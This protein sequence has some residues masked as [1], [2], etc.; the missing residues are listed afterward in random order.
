MTFAR[1]QHLA[2][3]VLLLAVSGTVEA[4]AKRE[5]AIKLPKDDI[6]VAKVN[7]TPIT[8]YDVEK[9][10]NHGLGN[11]AAAMSAEAYQRVREATIRSRAI[12]L[13]M[14]DELNQTEKLA[15][16]K[17]VAAFRE[18]L[19]VRRYLERHAPPSAVTPEAVRK[20]YDDH[21]EQFGGKTERTFELLGSTRALA[22][23]ERDKVLGAL[24]AV[25]TK[26]DWQAFATEAGRGL[27]L[28][29]TL[30]T[31]S[32][33]QLDRSLRELLDQ[34]QPG[35]ASP[36]SFIQGRAYVARIKGETQRSARPFEEVRADIEQMLTPGRLSAS[37]EQVSKDVLARSRVEILE[38]SGAE[39]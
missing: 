29:Y 16:E 28:S 1:V 22:P 13:A 6:V 8:R 27:P 10:A 11:L 38:N 19:L 37:V 33:E 34:L 15:L 2:S 25:D 20:Y 4:C 9:V 26:A 18:Q 23:V 5:K 12:S 21:P 36:V 24:K 31:S 30:T 14:T 7:D 35:Q 39:P 3:I 32:D 17:E